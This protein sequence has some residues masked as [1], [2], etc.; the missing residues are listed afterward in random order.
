M[1]R[2]KLKRILGWA[3]VKKFRTIHLIVY[4]RHVMEQ[5]CK[6]IMRE[7]IRKYGLANQFDIR[8]LIIHINR[9]QSHPFLLVL[10]GKKDLL[11]GSVY[12]Y[13]IIILNSKYTRNI[14]IKID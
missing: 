12:N 11:Y 2:E 14:V 1:A 7:R 8:N 5:E 3:N 10:S 6:M 4:V 13:L 9:F